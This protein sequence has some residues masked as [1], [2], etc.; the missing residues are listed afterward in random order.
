M[1][2]FWRLRIWGLVTLITGVAG[3]AYAGTF[4]TISELGKQTPALALLCLLV[5]AFMTAF[6]RT[7][8]AFLEHLKQERE[9]FMTLHKESLQVNRDVATALRDLERKL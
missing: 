3:V 7:V 6:W 4:E 1:F 8:T 2:L 5:L 9:A